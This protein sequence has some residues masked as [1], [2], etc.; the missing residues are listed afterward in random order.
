MSDEKNPRE[1]WIIH[2]QSVPYACDD[3]V[4]TQPLR[5]SFEV[6]V[7]EYSAYEQLKSKLEI[8]KKALEFYADDFAWLYNEIKKSDCEE[9][10]AHYVNKR[11]I[12]KGLFFEAGGKTARQAL[13]EINEG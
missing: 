1:F 6:H 11:P 3:T 7:I 9:I 2:G 5:D 13:K 8:A 10:K 12:P 4:H